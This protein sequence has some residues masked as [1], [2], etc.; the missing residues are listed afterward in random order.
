MYS[1]PKMGGHSRKH[2]RK[3]WISCRLIWT[4]GRVRRFKCGGNNNYL[5]QICD[6]QIKEGLKYLDDISQLIIFT[7]LDS[8]SEINTGSKVI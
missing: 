4:L 1:N 2:S 5:Q 6:G 7:K 3:A 8:Y